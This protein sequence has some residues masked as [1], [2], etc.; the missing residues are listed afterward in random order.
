LESC[1]TVMT[2]DVENYIEE[3]HAFERPQERSSNSGAL[4]G[5]GEF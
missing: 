2:N 4:S 3:L 5:L 1:T